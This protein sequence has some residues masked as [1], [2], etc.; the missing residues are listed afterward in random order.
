MVDNQ[1]MDR[2]LDRVIKFQLTPLTNIHSF[3]LFSCL[4]QLYTFSTLTAYTHMSCLLIITKFPLFSILST[5][6]NSYMR[7]SIISSHKLVQ[8]GESMHES[9]MNEMIKFSVRRLFK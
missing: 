8:S 6:K 9:Q 1:C 2:K 4:N 7:N 3:T 5:H